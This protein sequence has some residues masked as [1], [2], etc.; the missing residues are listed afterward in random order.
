MHRRDQ[1]VLDFFIAFSRFEYALKRCGFVLGG[2]DGAKADW[3]GFAKHVQKSVGAAYDLCPDGMRKQIDALVAAR[4]Q[5]QTEVSGV[6]AWE[7]KPPADHS[8]ASLTIYVRRFRNNLF[9]GAKEPL[10]D[11]D[12]W[13]AQVSLNILDQFLKMERDVYLEFIR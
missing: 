10:T 12:R 2:R 6:L 9:H 11:R 4:P 1:R 5:V 8:N 7:L 13:L 3:D